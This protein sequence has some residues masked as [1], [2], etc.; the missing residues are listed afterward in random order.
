MTIR[1]GIVKNRKSTGRIFR[2]PQPPQKAWPLCSSIYIGFHSNNSLIS[3]LVPT[4]VQSLFILNPFFLRNG[5]Q[6]PAKKIFCKKFAFFFLQH[7]C[8]YN[9]YRNTNRQDCTS[10]GLYQDR[11]V[12]VFYKLY[13]YQ[14]SPSRTV[15]VVQSQQY[16]P[17]REKRTR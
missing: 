13:S 4:S 14:N 12:L 10:I 1:C 15:L 5:L 2:D 17:S 3:H 16:S 8:A 9:P 11:T 6:I 7:Y